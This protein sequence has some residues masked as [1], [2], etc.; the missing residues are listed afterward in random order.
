MTGLL[1]ATAQALVTKFKNNSVVLGLADDS[2]YYGDQTLIPRSPTLCVEPDNKEQELR[3]GSRRVNA[4]VRHYIL[5]Y[6]SEVRSPQS[7]R[8][9]ADQ[10][11]EAVEDLIHADATLGGLLIHSYV[12]GIDSGY[13]TKQGVQWR[14][15]R[16]TFEGYAV[17]QL[18]AS[19]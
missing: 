10:L 6:H 15:S 4:T 5:L 3:G 19:P 13:P 7:N 9:E 17:R 16:I 1:V 18:P 14:G 11:A 12:T 2:V 8:L